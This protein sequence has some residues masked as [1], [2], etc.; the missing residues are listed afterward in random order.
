MMF[1]PCIYIMTNRPKGLPY[2]GVTSNLLKRVYEHREGVADGFTSRYDL[3]RLVH[4]EQYAT[5]RTAIVR[6]KQL[7]N[8]HRDWKVNLIE[9]ANPDWRDLAEDLGFEALE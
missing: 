9:E 2:I 3:H 4:F 5:M 8:W 6:E 1:Q 7:K